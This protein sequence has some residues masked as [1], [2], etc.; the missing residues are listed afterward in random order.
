MTVALKATNIHPQQLADVVH[1]ARGDAGHVQSLHERL[2][3]AFLT[4]PVA[5]DHLAAEHLALELEDFE[6]QSA[7]L[8]GDPPVV[9]TGAIRLVSA[10]PLVARGIGD[11]IDLR[12]K[13]PV[14]DLLDLLTHHPVELGLKHGLIELYDFLGHDSWSLS[15]RDFYCLA[16]ENRTKAGSCPFSLEPETQSTQ[17]SGRYSDEITGTGR[18]NARKE[19]L[20][21]FRHNKSTIILCL[22]Y[23]FFNKELTFLRNKYILKYPWK[24]RNVINL[25]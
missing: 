3:D 10:G 13:H 12:V 8:H 21:L 6:V 24:I 15:I 23:F 9:V 5:F 19:S 1:A 17:T 16:T 7:G 18:E 20:S 25:S 2:L 4:S 14:D 22:N 11:F